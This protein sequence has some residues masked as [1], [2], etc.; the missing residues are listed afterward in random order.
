MYQLFRFFVKYH[1]FFLFALI[2]LFAIWLIKQNNPY[3]DVKITNTVQAF[4]GRIQD[5]YNEVREYVYL[6]EI[7]D[8]LQAEIA[9][10]RGE[11]WLYSFEVDSAQSRT[12]VDSVYQQVY[13]YLSVKIIS[14]QTNQ[15]DNYILLN[16]GSDKGIEPGMGIIGPNGVIGKT[17]AVTN[18]YCLA[19]SVL[20]HDFK[21]SAMIKKNGVRGSVVWQGANSQ[22]GKINYVNVPADIAI[23]DT[24]VTSGF[25]T[26]FPSHIDLGVVTGF[27]LK[28]GDNFYD[29]DIK[30]TTYFDRLHYGYV[31]QHLR[32]MEI[33]SLG[34]LMYE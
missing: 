7:N 18:H 5:S 9:R 31:V 14:S 10:M 16:Q 34:Q 13:N 2:E 28:P 22:K 33:D 15:F 26:F 11:D 8:S 25:S 19:I 29:I 1:A 30:F 32:K 23:G 6:K 24:I 27:S 21:I 3:Q 4:T 17:K 12:V 20:H